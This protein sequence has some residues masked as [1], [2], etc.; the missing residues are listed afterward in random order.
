MANA[1]RMRNPELDSTC[2][3]LPVIDARRMEV[4]GAVYDLNLQ[5]VESLRAEV[6]HPNSFIGSSDTHVIVFGDAATKCIEVYAGN[7]NVQVDTSFEMTALGLHEI[8]MKRLADQNIDDLVSFEPRYLKEFVTKRK[9]GVIES[10]G[11]INPP[12]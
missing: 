7:P 4:Y 8:A 2:K 10:A 11:D 6:V 3:L 9:G 5:A 12:K 1:Y